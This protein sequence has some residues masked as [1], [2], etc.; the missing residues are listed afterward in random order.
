MVQGSN[1]VT[2]PSLLQVGD[3]RETN[4]NNKINSMNNFF[5]NEMKGQVLVQ[6][7]IKENS[8]TT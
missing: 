1:N 7:E 2:N 6:E 4:G 3:D 5:L 8:D